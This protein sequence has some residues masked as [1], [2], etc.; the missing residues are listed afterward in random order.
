MPTHKKS[1]DNVLLPDT[2]TI[3]P[4]T[5]PIAPIHWLMSSTDRIIRYVNI[6]ITLLNR[7][8]VCAPKCM[9]DFMC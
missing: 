7:V 2:Y 1:T 4:A 5:S 3:I 9:T 8:Y 6:M